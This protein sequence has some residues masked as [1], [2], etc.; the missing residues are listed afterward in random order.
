VAGISDQVA[1]KDLKRL[2]DCGLLIASGDRKGR[3]YQAAELVREI[4]ARFEEPKGIPDPF[5]RKV[6]RPRRAKA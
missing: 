5:A 6:S 4:R 2:V 3:T 1:T